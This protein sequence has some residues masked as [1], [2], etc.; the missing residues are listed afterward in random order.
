MNDIQMNPPKVNVVNP[1]RTKVQHFLKEHTLCPDDICFETVYER[2]LSEMKL[3]LNGKKSSLLMIPTYID[4]SDSIPA[5]EP[6]IVIDAGGTNLRTALASFD[7]DKKLILESFQNHPMPGTMGEVSKEAFFAEICDYLE[8]ILDRS[9]KISF[10]F[11]YP[12]AITPNRDGRVIA[13]SKEVRIPGLAGQ[14]LNENLL[15]EVRRRRPNDKKTAVLLNDTTATLIGGKAV[16]PDREFGGYVG[17]ILGTGV[18][19]CYVE[20]IKNIGKIAQTNAA[21]AADVD[22]GLTAAA[23][24]TT[25]SADDTI[26]KSAPATGQDTPYSS[27]IVNLESGGFD[28]LPF[29]DIDR[30]FDSKTINPGVCLYEKTVS[31]AYQ[32][33]LMLAIAQQAVRDGLFTSESSESILRLPALTPKEIDDFLF[34]PHGTNPL[35]RCIGADTNDALTLFYLIDAM[36]DRIA[37]FVTIKITAILQQTDSGKNPLFP[38]CVTADGTTFYKSK[39]LREKLGFYQRTYTRDRYGRHFEFVRAENAVLTG[40]AISALTQTHKI[41]R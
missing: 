6:V 40:T 21:A 17:L 31:G 16:F 36:M 41:L 39:L 38:V 11:S 19:A 12:V 20:D 24:G 22:T 4:L 3:G 2:F 15:E 5:G 27:M 7:R 13:M 33:G 10:C 34:Y 9:D 25:A 32:G 35:A 29:S 26:S 28:R 1:V 14:L 18:N 23:R 8:P 30:D 37:L